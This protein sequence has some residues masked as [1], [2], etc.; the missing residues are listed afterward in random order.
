[1]GELKDRLKSAR[2]E[3]GL[4]QEELAEKSGVKQQMIS[5]L[6]TGKSKETTGIVALATALRKNP[7]WLETG[8]GEEDAKEA[9]PD[10]VQFAKAIVDATP[11][12][13]EQVLEV[14]GLKQ[15]GAPQIRPLDDHRPKPVE[16]LAASALPPSEKKGKGK[17]KDQTEEI[18]DQE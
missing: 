15:T 1:M 5:K 11:Q 6:E 16:G 17:K 18:F 12:Q 10:M 2:N 13:L 4:T 3:A 9:L 14:L 7:V 8:R